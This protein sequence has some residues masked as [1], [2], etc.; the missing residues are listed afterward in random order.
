VGEVRTLLGLEAVERRCLP[1]GEVAH[2]RPGDEPAT[3]SGTSGH[4]SG[5]AANPRPLGSVVNASFC[6]WLIR[7]RKKYAANETIPPRIAAST[8]R[9]GS[10]ATGGT[11]RPPRRLG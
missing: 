1:A 2:D 11:P 5:G 7:S 4:H 8:S 3:A 9:P 10:A 6:T